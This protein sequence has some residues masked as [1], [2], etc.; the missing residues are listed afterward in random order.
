MMRLPEA[1]ARFA[2][3]R[4]ALRS[5]LGDYT[6]RD[7]RDIVLRTAAS[8]KPELVDT[9]G[10]HFSISHAADCALIGVGLTPVGVDMER[11]R[12]PYRMERTVARI[13]HGETVSLL[14]ALP[15]DQRLDAFFAAWTQRE[16]HVKAVGGGLFRTPDT[17][18]FSA[19]LEPGAVHTVVERGTTDVWSV[20]RL[21]S[22]PGMLATIVGHGRI[23]RII[24]LELDDD[25]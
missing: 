2:T 22:G 25:S 8:G 14:R 17:L 15:P 21:E 16:A 3:V 19:D 12:Q 24:N 1:R 7:P 10:L 4:A 18:P 6:G 11:V 13:F 23:E 20:G 9:D 5:I